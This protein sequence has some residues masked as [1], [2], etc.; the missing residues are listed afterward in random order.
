V[1][2]LDPAGSAA[3][4]AEFSEWRL[5][6]PPESNVLLLPARKS[7]V[8]IWFTLERP[9]YLSVDQSAGVVFSPITA[10]EIRRRAQNLLPIAKPDWQVMTEIKE[11]M[12]HPGTKLPPPPP[13]TASQLSSICRDPALGFVIAKETVG[14]NPL[15]HTHNGPYKDW[16][17][18]D[19]RH[20]R[21][22]QSAL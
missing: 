8:F 4:V 15:R 14:F 5:A 16:N 12:A 18:Y 17:L 6:I 3:Q 7:V 11:T 2:Q 21:A 1:K 22:L 10:E 13:L 19:C 9:S 20:V